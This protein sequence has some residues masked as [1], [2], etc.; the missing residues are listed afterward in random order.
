MTAS[1]LHAFVN[2]VRTRCTAK[3]WLDVRSGVTPINHLP[4]SSCVTTLYKEVLI[5]LYFSGV[6][7]FCMRTSLRLRRDLLFSLFFRDN[8]KKTLCFG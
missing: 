2:C 6:Y 3:N 4:A 5:G 8:Q 1:I 7:N